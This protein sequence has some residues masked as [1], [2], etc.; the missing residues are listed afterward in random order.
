MAA[1][2][3]DL[4]T[5]AT[6]G[7]RPTP[8][9][10]TATKSI[11]A[12]VVSCSAL[13]GWPTTTAVHFIIYNVS[14]A[15]AKIAGSQTDWKGIV[16]GSTITS[17]ILKA[18]TDN[19]YSI[20]AVVEAGPTAAWANDMVAANLAHSNQDGTLQANVVTTAKILDGNVTA[21]KLDTGAITLGYVDW[22][23]E[24]ATCDPTYYKW[25]Q[26]LFLKMLEKGIA[27]RKTQVV[28]S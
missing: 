25:N 7:T 28:W 10:L 24:I 8:T 12:G 20:G 21:S 22:S 2:I 26:W 3:T 14:T 13:S 18:G 19:G 17:I 6:N 5:Q 15:G 11:G 23:R 1:L 9:T 4:L 27:Y 16:S